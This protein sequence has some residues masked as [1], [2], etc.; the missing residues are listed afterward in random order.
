MTHA[1][2]ETLSSCA[3]RWA[4]GLTEQK[5]ITGNGLAC[6]RG[7]PGR[8]SHVERRRVLSVVNS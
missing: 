2:I 5:S 3:Q 6:C 1:P 7:H 8:L 4:I